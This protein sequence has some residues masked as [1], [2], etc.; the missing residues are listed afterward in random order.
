[1]FPIGS[2]SWFGGSISLS[3]RVVPKG[4]DR[5][6]VN[7]CQRTEQTLLVPDWNRTNVR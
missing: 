2:L 5:R 1:M 4:L 6:L 7:L 3:R